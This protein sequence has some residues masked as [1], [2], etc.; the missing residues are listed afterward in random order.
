MVYKK[1]VAGRGHTCG[2]YYS[3]KP[4]DR[5]NKNKNKNVKGGVAAEDTCDDDTKHK[6]SYGL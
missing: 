3:I 5:G 1:I 6:N 2:M 4:S